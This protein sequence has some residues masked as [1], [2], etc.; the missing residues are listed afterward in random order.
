MS[1]M[2]MRLF[3][4]LIIAVFLN[5]YSQGKLQDDRT[6]RI[7]APNGY[8]STF[9]CWEGQLPEV[10]SCRVR[11]GCHETGGFCEREA[12]PKNCEHQTNGE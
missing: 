12:Q 10:Q 1:N 3:Y 4:R 7:A 6:E 11:D 9:P 2:N 8:R 5:F